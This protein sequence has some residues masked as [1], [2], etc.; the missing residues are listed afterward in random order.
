MLVFK[1]QGMTCGGCAGSVKRAVGKAL[2]GSNV[3]V[4]LGRGLV[5]VAGI[6]TAD[7]SEKALAAI[8]AAGYEAHAQAA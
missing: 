6:A 8:R 5:S 4:D 2:P 7:A 3:E 1:V